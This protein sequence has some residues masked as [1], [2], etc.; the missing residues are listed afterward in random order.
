MKGMKTKM[1]NQSWGKGTKV[2]VVSSKS[3]LKRAVKNNEPNIR[4]TGKLASKIKWM[5][6][7]SP[8]KVTVLTGVL[9]LI[10]GLSVV[11]GQKVLSAMPVRAAVKVRVLVGVV[12]MGSILISG[13]SI[14][15]IIAVSRKYDM[16]IIG[17]EMRLTHKKWVIY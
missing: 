14:G 8:A 11:A 17:D 5:A 13:I 6:K 4:V 9:T 7:L 1:F 3:K 10:P 16:D 12:A 2:L 15:T